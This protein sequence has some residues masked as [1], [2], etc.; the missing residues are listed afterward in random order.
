[1]S[2]AAV[3]AVVVAAAV[4]EMMAADLNPCSLSQL[5]RWQER[6]VHC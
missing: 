2:A 4:L 3:A 6:F 1:M 5:P